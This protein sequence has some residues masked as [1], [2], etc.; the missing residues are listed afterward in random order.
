M[1]S[2]S[3]Q[4]SWHIAGRGELETAENWLNFCVSPWLRDCNLSEPVSSSLFSL[5][6]RYMFS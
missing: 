3:L 1:I 2:G 4:R 6:S 5:I